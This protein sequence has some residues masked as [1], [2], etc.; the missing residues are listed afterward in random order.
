MLLDSKN[1]SDEFLNSFVDQLL[2]YSIFRH[3][4]GMII[5]ALA[6]SLVDRQTE[7]IYI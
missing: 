4:T 2:R 7:L 3:K 1:C 5:F 6:L